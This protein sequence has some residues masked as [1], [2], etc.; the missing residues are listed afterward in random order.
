MADYYFRLYISIQIYTK[1]VMMMRYHTIITLCVDN[2][3]LVMIDVN[4]LTTTVW[5]LNA[6]THPAIHETRLDKFLTC[7]DTQC[8]YSEI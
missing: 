3:H 8:A 4:S 5:L 6:I 7:F 2:N 1:D